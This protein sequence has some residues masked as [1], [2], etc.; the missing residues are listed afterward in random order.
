MAAITGT[1]VN[2]T[3]GQRQ[4]GATVGFYKLG[5]QNGLEMIDQAKSDAQG[6]FT[7]NQVPQG[8]SLI[9]T[10]FDGVTYNHMLPPGSP[11]AGLT[12]DVFNSSMQPG[13]AKV[14]KHMILFQP[15]GGEMVVNETYLF[16]NDGKT[17]WNNPDSGTLH[18]YLPA[19]ANGK[20]EVNATAPGGMPIGAALV[21]SSKA[22][23]F[24][25]DFAIKPGETR[26]DLDYTV[27]YA[28]GEPYEGRI[29]SQDENS[30]LVAPNGVTLTGDGL[31]DLGVEPQSQ[32]HI[33]GLS[34]AAYK[35]ALT[36]SAAA[37][38][39]ASQESA[40]GD[41]AAASDGPS[42]EVVMPHVSGQ[43]PLI[44][45]LALGILALGFAILYRASSPPKETNERRR[46]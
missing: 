1:V 37:P 41:S 7:I 26:I 22:D 12:L 25:V 38:A 29:V 16:T 11:T 13:G 8:P 15:S 44:L 45:G 32:A 24:G 31:N 3:T 30:Y 34:A 2:R 18:F 46:G 6:N 36:G 43:V 35:I 4:A 28:E 19:A 40:G 17:A 27:P 21:K 23:V 9:R 39:P 33:Y 20:A 14:T 10:A 42:V 5:E